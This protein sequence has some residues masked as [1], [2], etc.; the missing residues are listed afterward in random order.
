VDGFKDYYKILG[1]DKKADEKEIK[2]AYRRLA[3]KYHPDVHPGD[4]E[5]ERRFREINEAYEVLSD[6]EK[7]QRYDQLGQY[8]NK[9]G[10]GAP[11]PQG[12]PGGYTVHFEGDLEDLLGGFGGGGFGPS[13]F[14]SFFERFFG[15]GATGGFAGARGP[16]AGRAAPSEVAG[17]VEITVEEAARGTTRTVSLQRESPCPACGGRG[18]SG[19]SVCPTCRGAGRVIS[20]RTLEVKIPKGVSTGSKIRVRGEGPEGGDLYLEVKLRPHP[21][22]EVRGH[23]LYREVPVS[24]YDAILGGEVSVPGLDGTLTIK[25]PPGTQNGQQFR[26]AGQGLPRPGGKGRGDLYARIKVELPTR[27]SDQERR[28]FTELARLRQGVSDAGTR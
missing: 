27:L 6:P 25:I 15:R 1:V 24:L 2:Q 14:S 20:P 18:L 19:Q 9:V 17:T 13:G 4:K 3:R 16:F 28:L 11:P 26:L 21:V 10:A 7:R 12:G 8:W 22:Y 5:A 23:D